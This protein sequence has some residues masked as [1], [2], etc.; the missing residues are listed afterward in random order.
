MREILARRYSLL[1]VAAIVTVA[2]FGA[3]VAA[4]A[5]APMPADAE[6]APATTVIIVRHAEKQPESDDPGLTIEGEERSHRLRDLAIDAGVTGLYA[7]QYRRT[8]AT[9]R[10]LADALGLEVD[11]IDARD[12]QALV[13]SILSA[14]AGRVVV[15][16]GHSNTVPGIVAA[17]GAPEPDEIPETDYDNLFV[18]TVAVSGDASVLRL[19]F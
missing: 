5:G 6:A 4:S 14:H 2:G 10:P 1:F 11:V 15:V 9:V 16:A 7:S 13:D 18:V 3:G 8:R 17:L 12:T 19:K